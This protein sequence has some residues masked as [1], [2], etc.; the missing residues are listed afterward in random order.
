MACSLPHRVVMAA[1]S[2]VGMERTTE[3]RCVCARFGGCCSRFRMCCPLALI[4]ILLSSLLSSPQLSSACSPNRR[5]GPNHRLTTKTEE[6]KQ[7]RQQKTKTKGTVEDGDYCW[8]GFVLVRFFFGLIL[9]RIAIRFGSRRVSV[10]RRKRFDPSA[11]NNKTKD[12]R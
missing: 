8:D 1:R 2:A 11:V 5:A 10:R 3:K 6:T 12:K 4:W 7:E 9:D